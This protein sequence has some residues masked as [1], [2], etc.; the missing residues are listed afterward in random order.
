MC[1]SIRNYE[2]ILAGLAWCRQCIALTWIETVYF[3]A[4]LSKDEP[5]LQEGL[6]MLM[7]ARNSVRFFMRA[8]CDICL[9]KLLI[10]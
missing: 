5:K 7:D 3:A 10:S 1:N 6:K 9:E 2:G 8:L 4:Q